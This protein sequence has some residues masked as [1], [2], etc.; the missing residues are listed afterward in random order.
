MVV[1]FSFALRIWAAP[2]IGLDGFPQKSSSLWG[3]LS[4]GKPGAMHL[5]IGP[6]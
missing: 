3:S 4:R 5:H 1:N 6:G 2:P